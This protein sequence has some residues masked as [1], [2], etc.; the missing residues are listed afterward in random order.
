MY[1]LVDV[2]NMYCSCERVF[3]P[4]LI[5]KPVVVLSNNDGCVI[6]RS[7]EAKKLGIP[8]GAVT[9]L[10]EKIFK[11]H[12]VQVYS[13]NYE[14]YG[15]LSDRLMHVLSKFT[16][17]IEVYSIDEAFLQFKGFEHF[18]LNDLGIEIKETILQY[19]GLPISIGIAPTKALAKVANRIA[20][21]FDKKT[22]G[23]YVMDSEHKRKKALNWL[24]IEDVWGIGRRNAS[25]LNRYG[26]TKAIQFAD[27]PDNWVRKEFSVVG[28]RLKKDLQGIPT[29]S[30][31]EVESKKSIAV[32]R[33]FAKTKNNLQDLK[34]IIA[35]YGCV[36]SEKLRVQKSCCNLIMVFV[37]SNRFRKDLPQYNNSLVVKLPYSTNSSL[38]IAKY[39]KKAIQS[40]FKKGYEFK[41]AG[42]MVMGLVPDNAQQLNMFEACNSDHKQLMSTIDRLN[43]KYGKN[44][45]NIASQKL[46]SSWAMRQNNLSQNYTTDFNDILV[47]NCNF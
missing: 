30:L 40:I 8:M 2:N 28:L 4:K 33:S 42:I 43:S 23:V 41:K 16:P 34:E 24:S 17:D 15:D 35:S 27:A 18:D 47:L 7:N 26:I 31:E 29:L 39:A 13:S 21:K 32:T 19:I 25:K 10:F 46:D 6:S 45:L 36:A 14:L 12:H 37:H 38:I 20:K 5:G 9:H 44:T 3:N 22:G 1:A 11:D